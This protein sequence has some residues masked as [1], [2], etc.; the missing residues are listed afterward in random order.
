MGKIGEIMR[1]ADELPTEK[2]QELTKIAK[3][4]GKKGK[5]NS[6]DTMEVKRGQ[7]WWVRDKMSTGAEISAGRPGVVVSNDK[8]NQTSDLI[9]VI[10]TTTQMRRPSLDVKVFLDGKSPRERGN[11]R[12]MVNQ[13]YTVDKSRLGRY[14]C[15]LTELEMQE[16][17]HGISLVLGLNDSELLEENKRL[18]ERLCRIERLCKL[19]DEPTPEHPVIPKK[20]VIQLDNAEPLDVNT[21]S[22]DQLR[23]I[24]ITTNI[25]LNIIAARP[26][27][28]K[29]DLIIVP[30]MNRF[31]F[32]KI[33]S[34]I[35]VNPPAPEPVQEAPVQEAPVQEA[36]KKAPKK[37]KLNGATQKQL[38]KLGLTPKKAQK[39]VDYR[40][41]FGPFKSIDDLKLIHGF[42]QSSI[43]KIRNRLEV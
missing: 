16:I 34:R 14:I 33:E 4:M 10:Y 21:C 35:V 25:C 3:D 2:V 11:C 7:V 41:E 38:V 12:A 29:E 23:A 6:M 17:S 9:Q 13:I 30:G 40:S 37:I 42:G 26:Y 36:P 24:G 5:Q 28:S 8:Y 31:I 20:S 1:A 27:S 39:V 19:E 32:E 15:N 22:F 43:A 18:Q